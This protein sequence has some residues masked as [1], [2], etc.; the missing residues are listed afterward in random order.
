MHHGKL[1]SA[2]AKL[3][4]L[5]RHVHHEIAIPGSAQIIIY[6]RVLAEELRTD[7]AEQ[8]MIQPRQN[9]RLQHPQRMAHAAFTHAPNAYLFFLF[10]QPQNLQFVSKGF[11]QPGSDYHQVH[12]TRIEEGIVLRPVEEGVGEKCM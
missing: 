3:N 9:L 7:N 10:I 4:Y 11:R 8:R 5:L 1:L 12:F 2:T 6:G